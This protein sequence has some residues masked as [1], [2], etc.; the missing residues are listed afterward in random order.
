MQNFD[1]QVKTIL[2]E[3]SETRS[4]AEISAVT[5]LSDSQI[6]K[7]RSGKAAGTHKVLNRIMV[8]L[9]MKPPQRTR[10]SIKTPHSGLERL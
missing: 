8:A 9:G 1:T 7:L 2:A 4:V 3:L 5:K 6:R 10:E